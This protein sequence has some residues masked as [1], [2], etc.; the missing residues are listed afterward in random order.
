M[1]DC[2]KKLAFVI[3]SLYL[4]VPNYAQ[5][6]KEDTIKQ[7]ELSIDG[8][9]T[10]DTISIFKKLNLDLENRLLKKKIVKVSELECEEITESI[11]SFYKNEGFFDVKVT[12]EEENERFKILIEE[13]IPYKVKI[14]KIDFNEENEIVKKD[15]NEAKEEIKIKEG[16]RFRTEDYLNAK[17]I[18][19]LSL[20]N[21]GFPYAKVEEKAIVDSDLKCVDIYY[22]VN[23]GK[24]A[25]F[26]KTIFEGIVH[27]E[28]K[29]LRRLIQYREG[30]IFSI[31]KID[32]T[33]E[34]LYKSGLFDIV[35]IKV[36]SVDEEGFATIKIILK[37]GRH[38]KVKLS[39]GYG[40]DEKV[41]FQ[42]QFETTRIGDKYYNAGVNFKRSSLEKSYEFHIL[43]P[44]YYSDFTPFVKAKRQTLHWHQTDFSATD[45]EIGAQKSFKPLQ[46]TFNLG[47]EKIDKITFTYPFPEIKD[48]A[49]TPKIF[50][51]HFNLLRNTTDNLLDPKKGYIGAIYLEENWVDNGTTFSKTTFDIR[52]YFAVYKENVLAFKFRVSSLLTTDKI[53]SIP[54]PYRIFTGGQI[55]LRGYRFSSISP[56]TSSGALNGGKGSI[57]TSFEYR[58]LLKDDLK[59]VLFF[60]GGRVTK[61]SNPFSYSGNFKSDIGFG[62]RY[63]TPVGPIGMDIAFR[64]NKASYSPSPFQLAFY[65]GYSF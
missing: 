28:E 27:S 22:T 46:I 38:R 52:K 26:G 62:L 31:S 57:E 36:E 14:L 35:T 30:D 4:I 56:L 2:I 60:D 64:L 50:F 10:F 49:L 63:I 17:R 18:L 12:K 6:G 5:K 1:E 15:C 41:R 44:Y 37:E 47:Y 45:L 32:E 23:E 53:T 19:T 39:L 65:I 7:K 33:K 29:I 24:R 61:I 11:A 58:F 13:G 54:Y 3:F 34:S 21:D 8:N 43:R 9:S 16:E 48:S 59:G 55:R 20:Q 25:R 42:A 51:F 40:T